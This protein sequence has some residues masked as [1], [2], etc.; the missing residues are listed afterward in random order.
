MAG[1]EKWMDIGGAGGGPLWAGLAMA[2]ML[3][4]SIGCGGDGNGGSVD[5][6]EGTGPAVGD[7]SGSRFGASGTF[8]DIDGDG[9]VELLVGAPEATVAEGKG[10][11][12]AYGLQGTALSEE[13]VW[14]ASGRSGGDH[15]GYSLSGLGDVNGDGAADFA[16]GAPYAEGRTP[17]SG[18][19]YVYGGGQ[20]G[21]VLLATLPGEEAQDKFGYAVTGGDLNGDGMADVVVTGLHARGGAYQSGVVYVYK[22]GRTLSTQPD[23]RIPGDHVNGGTGYALETGDFNGDGVADLFVGNHD[24]VKIYYGGPNFFGN[25]RAAAETEPDVIIH[26]RP[27]DGGAHS[28]A[29]FGD[30]LLYA[31]D[32]TGDGYGDL[33]LANPLRVDPEVY[34]NRGCVYLFRGGPDLPSE[35]YENDLT[36]RAFKVNGEMDCGRFGWS[37]ILIGNE[38]GDGSADLLVSAPWA[39]GGA[40]GGTPIAGGV[41]RFDL[42]ELLLADGGG[43]DAGQ[44]SVVY[45]AD[46]FSGEM[47]NAL[48]ATEDGLLFAGAPSLDFND[49]GGYLVSMA[50]GVMTEIHFKR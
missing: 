2:L 41:Y 38:N 9:R 49:G 25:A 30:A 14:S 20:D 5:G 32:V 39:P 33:L 22:G 34:D 16:A 8:A 42:A 28:G 6:P 17:L 43:I 15:Y 31:G 21:P 35:F 10:A 37:M 26:G 48:C 1:K 13:A 40:D 50:D 3:C 18:A 11:V 7:L 29:G 4:L 36:H 45:H 19:V 27:A 44:A 46:S 12:V 47:G 23:V 24:S